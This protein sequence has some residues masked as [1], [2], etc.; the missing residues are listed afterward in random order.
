MNS[1]RNVD[2]FIAPGIHRRLI[3][4]AIGAITFYAGV[5]D[6]RLKTFRSGGKTPGIGLE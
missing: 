3:E 1:G 5:R 4:V 2:I 6:Q